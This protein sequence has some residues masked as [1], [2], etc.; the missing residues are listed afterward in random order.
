MNGE[1]INGFIIDPDTGEILRSPE[2]AGNPEE[3]LARLTHVMREAGAQE[4]AWKQRAAI[5]KAAADRILNSL[6][7]TSFTT[8]YGKVMQKSRESVDMAM[9]PALQADY[10]LS[11]AAVNAIILG[12]VSTLNPSKFKDAAISA[13]LTVEAIGRALTVS[14]WVEAREVPKT[15]PEREVVEA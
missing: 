6:G 1:L 14:H 15:A 3:Q 8:P 12:S 7:L 4:K 5:A 13:G 2:D 10:E 11:D 9:L